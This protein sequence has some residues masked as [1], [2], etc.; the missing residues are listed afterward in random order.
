MTNK[1]AYMRKIIIGSSLLFS[2]LLAV[3]QAH[4]QESVDVII[5]DNGTER[6]EV[7]DLPKSMTYPVDSLLNDWKAKKYIDLG[8][9]CSTPS[10]PSSRYIATS[11]QISSNSYG[12]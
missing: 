5:H 8:K 4:A 11:S 3:T 6:R 7:I 12:V 2:I 10:A 9:D 1:P